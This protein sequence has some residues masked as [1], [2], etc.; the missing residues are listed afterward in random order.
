MLIPNMATKASEACEWF[1]PTSVTI[2][3]WAPGGGEHW[4]QWSEWWDY[5]VLHSNGVI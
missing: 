2:S 4:A 3:P 1:L 5:T